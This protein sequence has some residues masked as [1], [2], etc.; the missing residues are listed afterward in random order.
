[1]IDCEFKNTLLRYLI[2]EDVKHFGQL[3]KQVEAVSRIH[4]SYMS[5]SWNADTDF[6]K[7]KY[8]ENPANY[9]VFKVA[10]LFDVV[11]GYAIIR[12]DYDNPRVSY[13]AYLAI[14]A[15]RQNHGIGSVL[16]SHCLEVIR[17]LGNQQLIFE[18]SDKNRNFYEDFALKN[19]LSSTSREIGQFRDGDTKI[20][21][22]LQIS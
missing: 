22:T 8:L 6:I 14:H 1:M 13:L 9:Q 21:M 2:L 11:C 18:C 19:N 3:E 15:N 7:R 16:L 10:K 20:K 5:E 12:K 4:E 17:A